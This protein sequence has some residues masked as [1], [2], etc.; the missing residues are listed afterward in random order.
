MASSTP[1][2]S[3]PSD[4]PVLRRDKHVKYWL[5]CLKTFLPSAYTS[6]DTNRMTLAFFI[7]S[8]LDLLSA[9]DS[10]V[11]ADE[12]SDYI[13]WIYKC[14]HPSGGFRGFSGTNLGAAT[15]EENR[16]WDTASVAAT[17]S[18]LATLIILGDDLKQVRRKET[19]AWLKRMQRDDGSFGE[20]M[21]EG[22]RIEGGRDSRFCQ[23]AAAIRWVLKGTKSVEDL[24]VQDINVDA[25]VKYILSSETYDGGISEGPFFEAHAGLTFCS[26]G[27]LSSLGRLNKLSPAPNASSASQELRA[28]SSPET[29]SRWLASRQTQTVEEPDEENTYGDETDSPAT[30]HDRHAFISLP[31][32]NLQ[33]IIDPYSKDAH[34][35]CNTSTDGTQ[36]RPE[37][38]RWAGFNGRANKIADTCYSFW[39]LGS[40]GILDGLH[41]I[42][43]EAARNHLLEKTQHLIGGFGKITGDPPDLIHSYLGLAALGV[44]NT[45]TAAPRDTQPHIYELYEPHVRLLD[46]TLC[47]SLRAKDHLTSHVWTSW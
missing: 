26:L 43:R 38:L 18:A 3:A 2:T 11:S 30:C 42:D 45:A 27:A 14:Q 9:L 40:L 6:M 32:A 35:E 39:V 7:V 24:G 20:V 16:H 12:R 25:T 21:T 46:P 8:A 41:V 28:P 36:Q 13:R 47:I 23:F 29:L 10:S 5:R 15:T 33:A 4:R 1:P 34:G 37:S 17:Y 31:P 44:V 22:G 19:L